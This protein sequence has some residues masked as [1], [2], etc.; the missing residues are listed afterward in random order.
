MTY[1]N[2]II[3]ACDYIARHC[4]SIADTY[5]GSAWLADKVIRF[6]EAEKSA[7]SIE[8]PVFLNYPVRKDGFATIGR[9]GSVSLR[10]K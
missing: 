9:D 5:H 4:T 6:F 7:E 8:I 2:N 1:Y 10:I 3:E